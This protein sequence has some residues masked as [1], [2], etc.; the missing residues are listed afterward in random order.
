MKGVMV[1][2]TLA[3]SPQ[4]RG[5]TERVE[6]NARLTR[7][8]A[9]R[10]RESLMARS[11]HGPKVLY[12]WRSRRCILGAG[13]RRGMA[14][15]LFRVGIGNREGRSFTVWPPRLESEE[16]GEV[17]LFFIN[18]DPLPLIG[19]VV[20]ELQS[21]ARSL[22]ERWSNGFS[23]LPPGS[24][25]RLEHGWQSTNPGP[26]TKG[27]LGEGR[28]DDRPTESVR[29]TIT[30]LQEGYLPLGI[31][32]RVWD[33]AER[34]TSGT[35]ARASGRPHVRATPAAQSTRGWKVAWGTACPG[36]GSP[37]KERWSTAPTMARA[38][39]G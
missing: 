19:T 6:R 25:Q 29:A 11:V 15:A 8:L 32:R 38:G 5:N 21:E 1:S 28:Y 22:V 34:Y 14:T 13:H 18:V 7:P 3:L 10:E 23:H 27:M 35:G 26:D 24:H 12:C 36:G 39:L 17:S 20:V 2:P 4:G 16:T 9:P 37:R 33:T 30:N 31:K